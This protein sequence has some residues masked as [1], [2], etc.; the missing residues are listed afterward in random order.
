MSQELAVDLQKYRGQW[1]GK[2]DSGEEMWWSEPNAKLA[3]GSRWSRFWYGMDTRQHFL[4]RF[5]R[6]AL[7]GAPGSACVAD[8]GCGTGGTTL[9]LS[10][11]LGRPITGYDLF[12]T[13]LTIAA[14]MAQGCSGS[15]AARCPFEKLRADGALPVADGAIDLLLSVDVLGHVPNIER[16]LADLARALRPGGVVAL[17]TE[18]TY[19]EGDSSLMA[20]L[21]REGLDMTA[22]V[23]EHISLVPREQLEKWFVA[24]G[25]E[26]RERF[27]ANVCHFLFFPKDYVLLLNRGGR[28]QHRVLYWTAWVWD[29]VSKVTPFYPWPFQILRTALTHLLGRRAFGTSYFYELKRRDRC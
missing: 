16:T 25:F 12:P 7:A 14:A 27:S 5:A 21:A 22:A 2:I 28:A 20:R 18:S 8:F 3:R 9:N 15:V 24:A 29:R 19:S 26:I 13:Q 11:A 10:S 6:R 1:G 4:L 23:T 17:F